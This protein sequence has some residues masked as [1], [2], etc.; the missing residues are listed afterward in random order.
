MA[1]I[2]GLQLN[3][4]IAVSTAVRVI[5]NGTFI[6]VVQ[7]LEP[8]QTRGT[9]PVRGIG[10]GDRILQRVW[11]VSDYQLTFNKMALFSKFLFSAIYGPL[12]AGTPWLTNM[13][14][15]RMIAEL[16]EPLDIQELV[17]D[18]VT[19]NAIRTTVYRGCYLNNYTSPRSIS[20]GDI[21]IMETGTFDVTSIDDGG[22]ES[23]ANTFGQFDS[24]L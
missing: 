18:P 15:F 14:S 20:G 10:I 6:G 24:G 17:V 12:Q 16:R 8:T 22:T 7:S 4:K 9:T 19:G 13:T 3:N 2:D 21:I 11:N 23:P 1:L 5:I